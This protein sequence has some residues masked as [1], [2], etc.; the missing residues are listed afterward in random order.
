M[1]DSVKFQDHESSISMINLCLLE[2]NAILRETD[3]MM[4]VR[5][6]F[7]TTLSYKRL[8]ELCLSRKKV[9][10]CAFFRTNHLVSANLLE[11]THQN[12]FP[13]KLKL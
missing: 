10:M 13:I 11:R 6:Q 1:Y 5:N 4:R 2:V 9:K 8:T 12:K 3:L 7:C